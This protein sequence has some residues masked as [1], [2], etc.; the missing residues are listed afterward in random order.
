MLLIVPTVNLVDQIYGDFESYNSKEDKSRFDV[1]RDCC[2]WHATSTD[3]Y[4]NQPVLISTWQSLVRQPKNFT[5]SFELF[6]V[7]EAHTAQSDSITKI[8]SEMTSTKYRFGTTGTLSDCKTDKLVLQGLIGKASH[9]ATFRTMMD[10]AIVAQLQVKCVLLKYPKEAREAMKKCLYSEE[11]DIL[12][13][14]ELR[15]RFIARLAASRKGNTL[16]LFQLVEKHG[17]LLLPIIEQVVEG[18]GRKVFFLS[19]AVT[20]K[21]REEIRHILLEETDA[22]LVASYGVFSVGA[23]VPNLQHV[24]MASPTKSRIKLLQSIGRGLRRGDKLA[25]AYDLADDLSWR[26]HENYGLKHF[27]RRIAIYTEEQMPFE[28]HNYELK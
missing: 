16:V 6:C 2:R 8:L 23:N 24:I 1:Q 15:N 5:R 22:I 17:K 9:I 18:T 13:S 19:G 28:I 20:A 14:L 4:A 12:A 3:E 11:V 26:K 7:D 21:K 27:K 10:A 25:Y